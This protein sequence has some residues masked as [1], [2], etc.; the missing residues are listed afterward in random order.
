MHGALASGVLEVVSA[1]LNAIIILPAP[2]VRVRL[3]L[4]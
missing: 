3:G 2:L 1:L 4:I